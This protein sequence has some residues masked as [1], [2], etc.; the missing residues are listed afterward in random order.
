MVSEGARPKGGGRSEFA[1]LAHPQ[2]VGDGPKTVSESTVSNTEHSEFFGPHRVPGRELSE[3][4]SAYYLCA[5][6]K[7][8]S[9]CFAELTEFAVKLS[10]FSVSS[11]LRFSRKGPF[12]TKNST[13]LESVLFCRHRS[14]SVSV[15]FSCLFFLEKQALLSPPRSVL[16]RP[17]R[18]CFPYRNSLSVQFFVRKGPLGSALETVFRPFS[19]WA[20]FPR[21]AR[22]TC[23]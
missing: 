17:Y 2:F 13:A 7:S 10:E 21:V 23:F 18:I 9:F 12:R 11:L 8:P 5:K 1:N 22:R 20:A 14:F 6:A 4:L 19:S 16:L 3:F 15:L